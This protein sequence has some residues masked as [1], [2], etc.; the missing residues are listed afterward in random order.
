MSKTLTPLVDFARTFLLEQFD[1]TA[2]AYVPVTAGAVTCYLATSDDAA[3]AAD[4]S[5]TGS[6]SYIGGTGASPAGT[7]FLGLDAAVLTF[8]LLDSLFL[9]AAP[10]FIVLKPSGIRVAEKLKYVRVRKATLV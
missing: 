6:A 10:Y 1:T 3:T 8:A 9:N 4:P 7:W 5:L 2:G